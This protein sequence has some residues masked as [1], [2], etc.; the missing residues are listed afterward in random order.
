MTGIA[1]SLSILALVA[2]MA[3]C[4]MRRTGAMGA[5]TVVQGLCVAGALLASTNV[6]P[7]LLVAV[8]GAAAMPWSVG[9]LLPAATRSAESWPVVAAG[10]IGAAVAV[11]VPEVG[12]A[13][14][15]LW[16]GLW[17][18][19]MRPAAAERVLALVTM[20]N[21]IVLA[22]VAHPG[23]PLAWTVLAALPIPAGVLLVGL[24]PPGRGLA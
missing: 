16:V 11:T 2:A 6:L 8:L 22:A 15:L 19:T 5:M 18:V 3:G 17:Q 9:T 7:A 1:A 23:A 20:Q 21:G 13:L 14:A 4:A 24:R 12:L 10:L